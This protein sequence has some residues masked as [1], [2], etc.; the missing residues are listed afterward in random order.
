MVFGGFAKINLVYSADILSSTYVYRFEDR[1]G[2]SASVFKDHAG[3]A[4]LEATNVRRQKKHK[5]R[6][7]NAH[8]DR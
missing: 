4:W 3:P 1:S 2:I 8:D 6:P 5:T 7:E